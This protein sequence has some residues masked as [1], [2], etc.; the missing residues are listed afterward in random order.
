MIYRSA[1]GCTSLFGLFLRYKCLF[2]R[3]VVMEANRHRRFW[4][5]RRTCYGKTGYVLI[6]RAL[7]VGAAYGTTIATAVGVT[8]AVVATAARARDLV[9]TSGP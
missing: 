2:G 5:F 1:A 9:A 3:I 7:S 8:E 6:T 4:I